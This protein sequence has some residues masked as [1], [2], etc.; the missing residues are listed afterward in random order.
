MEEKKLDAAESLALIGRMIE[1]TRNRMV[2]NAG[3]PLLVWGYS[4]I[5]TTLIVWGS[6]VYFREPRWNYLWML[7][8]VLG[9]LGMHF[10]RPEKREGEVHT[11]I[12]RVIGHVWLVMGL[13]AWFVSMLTLF[14]SIRM[15]ILFIILVMMGMGTAATGL[16]IRF[17][18][19]TAGGFAA[20]ALAPLSFVTGA[21]W[22]PLVFIAGFLIM[23]VI[24]G[25]I[26]NY[27]SN[28]LSG[29]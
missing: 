11:F 21:M 25:H 5:L 28:R 13:S 6:V 22:Q 16:I 15:P 2:R 20:I 12:D 3:R 4:T 17:T 23:M 1:N 24:P 7:I 29:Q 8:P 19:A 18:P 14:T 27:K 26:L 9:W 10:T